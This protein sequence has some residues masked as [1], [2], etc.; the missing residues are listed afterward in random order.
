VRP[1]APLLATLALAL[2]P[3]A[4][5]SATRVVCE[6]SVRATTAWVA[7]ASTAAGLSAEEKRVVCWA[8]EEYVRRMTCG[9]PVVDLTREE[10][11]A[12]T[13]VD[14]DRLDADRLR[15]ATASALATRIGSRAPLRP[16]S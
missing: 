14:V 8:V 9:S 4:R 11:R 13:G 5:P 12:A 7:A 2:I 6:A 3:N 15:S 10:V 16:R 1:A